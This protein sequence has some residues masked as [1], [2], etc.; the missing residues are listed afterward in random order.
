MKVPSDPKDLK[1]VREFLTTIRTQVCG[2][3]DNLSEPWKTHFTDL[4][5]HYDDALASLPPTD[6]V[7]AAMEANHNLSCFYSC[8]ANASALASMLGSAMDTMVKKNAETVATALASAVGADIEKQI[9]AGTLFKPEGIQIKLTAHVAELT[10]TGE[11][12]LKETL[13]Q[14]CSEASRLGLEAGE[15]KVRDEV[16][17]TAAR[18]AVITTRKAGLQTCGLP[19]PDARLE[20]V[21]AGTEDEFK[22]AQTLAQNRIAAL[23]KRGVALN[24]NSPLGAK[25][26]LP[27]EQWQVFESLAVETLKGGGDPLVTSPATRERPRVMVC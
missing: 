18:Q 20:S 7:P 14:L 6:Q 9:A 10:K 27:E 15:K 25:V 23:Q 22:A 13:T 17:A 5:K 12:V 4:K 21:L 3:A 8:L 26:W 19:V 2:M 16:V 11:L 1:A 24:S